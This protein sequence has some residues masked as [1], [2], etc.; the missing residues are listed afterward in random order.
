MYRNALKLF[1]FLFFL[2][3]CESKDNK[4]LVEVY[5]SDFIDSSKTDSQVIKDCLCFVEDYKWKIVH[6]DVRNLLIDEAIL[7]DANT[8][9]LLE[10]CT[11]KQLDYTFDNVFR[12]NNFIID[13]ED[14]Y[15]YP[16]QINRIENIRIIGDGVSTIIGPD[17]NRKIDHYVLGEQEAIGDYYGWRTLQIC[18]SMASN[19]EI[20][21]INF[22]KTRCWCISFDKC[23]YLKLHDLSIYSDC[24]NGDGIDLRSGCHHVEVYNITGNT[25]DD[26]IALSAVANINKRV[27]PDGNKIYPMEPSSFM[28]SNIGK[29]DLDIHD[30]SIYNIR[31]TGLMHGLIL[32]T[33][34]EHE[35]YNVEVSDFIEPMGGG[36]RESII[37]LYTGYGTLSSANRIHDVTLS[38]IVSCNAK[39]ALLC[40]TKC[41]NIYVSNLIQHNSFGKLFQLS[42]ADG[43]ILD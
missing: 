39:Y 41:L 18:F 43:F 4:D 3:S 22:T 1:V 34:N 20:S 36:K 26:T 17:K 7:L 40:N 11:I 31:T 12:G 8:T 13:Q 25:S 16:I 23:S 15:G 30:V 5:L 24:K 29:G 32:L 19:I 21:G 35:I 2:L 33:A 38:N 9:V 14:P 42:D 37:K 10:N 28:F 6:F 27:Y